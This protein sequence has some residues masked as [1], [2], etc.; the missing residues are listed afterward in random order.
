MGEEE[1]VS[2]LFVSSWSDV[3]RGGLHG[4]QVFHSN[5]DDL[6]SMSYWEW[7]QAVPSKTPPLRQESGGGWDTRWTLREHAGLAWDEQLGMFVCVWCD[8]HFP[9]EKTCQT[10]PF[11]GNEWGD[12][13]VFSLK[14]P[15]KPGWI[16]SDRLWTPGATWMGNA[17]QL[18]ISP[19]ALE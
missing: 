19:L 8:A 14:P 4:K 9:T 15:R 17:P 13:S 11:W 6:L 10:S 16:H 2:P 5:R 12:G 1:M 7:A 18:R 3:E